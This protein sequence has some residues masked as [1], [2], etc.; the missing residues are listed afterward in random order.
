MI[1]KEIEANIIAAIEALNLTGL[2]IRGAWQTAADGEVKNTED[3]SPA[4]LSVAVSPRSFE[5]YNHPE[6]SLE[7]AISL[8]IRTDLCPSGTAL[9]TYCDPVASLLQSWNLGIC[10][11]AEVTGFA[12]RFI[13]FVG[14]SGPEFDREG[15]VW[16]VVFHL[17]FRGT[18]TQPQS[19]TQNTQEES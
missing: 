2:A 14:G 7:I 12:P 19:S 1:E 16:S 11:P 6:I 3:S 5:K 17:T 9:E 18:V 10:E 8:D 15:A 13:Q 4:A